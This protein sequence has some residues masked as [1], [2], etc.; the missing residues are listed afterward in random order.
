MKSIHVFIN[1]CIRWHNAIT[2]AKSE[3]SIRSSVNKPI[4]TDMKRLQFVFFTHI[5][6]KRYSTFLYS[7]QIY[8]ANND[9][10][11]ECFSDVFL[12]I[13][14]LLLCISFSNSNLNIVQRCKSYQVSLFYFLY[15][16]RSLYKEKLTDI[17]IALP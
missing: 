7:F 15:W 1:T 10:Q 12:W 11:K 16:L 2:L 8:Y 9:Q 6:R 14:T 5:I 17:Q 3:D 4:M 13:S